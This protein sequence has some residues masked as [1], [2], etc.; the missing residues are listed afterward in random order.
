MRYRNIM[1]EVEKRRL[2]GFWAGQKIDLSL[3][4]WKHFGGQPDDLEGLV[5]FFESNHFENVPAIRIKQDIWNA[6]AI[7]QTAGA[8]RVVGHADVNTLSAVL[9]YTDIMI[10]GRPMTDVIRDK[11][12]LDSKFDTAIYSKDEHDL[13]IGALKE[14]TCAE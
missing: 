13:I 3:A 12:G 7:S 10:L 11:L 2:D 14:M 8:K 4:L 1:A 9:P 5:S 6:V